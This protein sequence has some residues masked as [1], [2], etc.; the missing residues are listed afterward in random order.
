VVDP[1]NAEIQRDLSISHEKIGNIL[2]RSGNAAG[3]LAEYRQSL[4]IDTRLSE[5]DPDNAQAQLDRASSQ[6][7]IGKLL[8][9]E[10]DLSGALASQDRARELRERVAAKDEKNVEVRGDLAADYEQLGTT[11]GLLGKKSGNPQYLRD[12]CRW[13]E[14][15]L[16]VLR[17]LQK[18]GTFDQDDAEQMKDITAE[19]SKCD[20]AKAPELNLRLLMP[21]VENEIDRSG[22]GLAA[23]PRR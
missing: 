11:N 8:V 4:N 18:R 7:N 16:E 15:G 9:S 20:L 21:A 13:Y 12:A 3:A 10:G 17:D 5:G 19:A 1:N 2:V 6:E 22:H 23:H 14:R